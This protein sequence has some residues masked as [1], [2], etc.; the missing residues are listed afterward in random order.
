MLTTED[1]IFD[2]PTQ[3]YGL[4]CDF[5]EGVGTYIRPPQEMSR[6][7]P[8]IESDDYHRQLLDRQ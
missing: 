2:L 7:S 4:D 3:D 6:A 5:W 1:D 8:D